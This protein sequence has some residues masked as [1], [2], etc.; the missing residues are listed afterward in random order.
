[1]EN[2]SLAARDTLDGY[3]RF[4][5]DL[6]LWTP[7]VEAV[8]RRHNLQP[9]GP[10]RLGVPG[11]CPAFLVT[12]RWMVK[13]FGQLFDGARSFAAEREAAR[14]AAS[15]PNVR[16]VPLAGSGELST[17]GW[18]WPYLIFPFVPG[19][20]IGAQ[21]DGLSL[22]HKL[23]FA[24]ELGEMIR[25]LHSLPLEGSP[26]FPN[27]HAAH[28]RF[29]AEQRVGLSQRLRQWANLPE[30]LI[31]TVEHFLPHP[32]ALIDASRPPHLI[33][34]DLTGDHLLG[35]LQDDHWRINALIDFGDA[36]TGGLLYELGALQL[37]LFRADRRL[38]AAFLDAYGLP[39]AQRASLPDKALAAALLHQFDLFS[40][41]PELLKQAT[42][43][44]E[45]AQQLFGKP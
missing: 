29:L 24:A 2:P 14:L 3:R 7:Y 22:Q 32:D 4:F 30:H 5:T 34:A 35:S 19:T 8:L 40:A 44:P 38:L 15:D 42:G 16:A 26:V 20:P 28:R 41:V 36:R 31:Q 37:D 9:L 17:Q 18:P 45:L 13:F 33:H 12:E 25:R 11:T 27:T 43:L 1:M 21:I 6:A 10:V 23:R 39:P